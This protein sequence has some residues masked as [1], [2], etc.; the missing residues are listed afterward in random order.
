M[1]LTELE[2][3]LEAFPVDAEPPLVLPETV[4]EPELALWELVLVTLKLLL[5]VTVA[6]V[7][8]LLVTWLF[9]LGPV[10][11]M[12]PELEPP[13]DAPA[14]TPAPEEALFTEADAL[15]VFALEAAPLLAEPA[16][17]LPV[18]LAEPLEAPWP[19]LL[20]TPRLLLLFTLAA[21]VSLL[22]TWLLELGPV[23]PMLP[24]LAPT[25]LPIPAMRLSDVIATPATFT[26]FFISPP[27]EL[28]SYYFRYLPDLNKR[29]VSLTQA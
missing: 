15:K 16:L 26:I 7:V 3:L 18:V 14:N 5:L 13:P 24:E 2:L 8:L 17:V 4:A 19:L 20:E 27:L 21:H 23:V 11:E 6:V 12:V 29:G 25:M 22:V 28:I 9:E 10:V 1:K